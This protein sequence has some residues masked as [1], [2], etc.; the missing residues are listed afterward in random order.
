M[1]RVIGLEREA[2]ERHP[3]HVGL[4]QAGARQREVNGLGE[5]RER[6]PPRFLGNGGLPV[7]RDHDALVVLAHRSIIFSAMTAALR[8]LPLEEQT[9]PR[10]LERQAAA[11]GGKTL[12]RWGTVERSFEAMRDTAA[13]M[14]GALAAGGIEPG[15]RVVVLSENRI[16]MLDLWLGCAWRGAA[17]VPVNPAL[18]GEQLEHAFAA[19]QPKL[20]VSEPAF[21]VPAAAIAPHPA[22]PGDTAAVLYTSGSTGPAKGV[23]CPHA[24][25]YWWGILTGE[26]L[27]LGEDDVLYTS[28]PLF[29]T[30][31]LNAFCQALLAGATY[32][33]GPRFSAS[34]FWQR[35]RDA[36]AT[37]TYLLGAM[38]GILARGD[39]DRRHRV[40]VALAPATLPELVDPFRERFGVRLVNAWGSTETNLVITPPP[41]EERP[42]ALG[43]VLPEFEA[44]LDEGELVVR[45]RVPF[46]F[47]TGYLG[48]ADGAWQNGWFY[49]GDR[50]RRDD[51]DWFWFVDRTKDVIRRRGE[52]IS[53]W[54]VEQALAAH[55]SVEAAAVVPVPS[56][57]GEEEVLA[58][59]VPRGELDP[60]E[61]VRFCEDRLAHFA[62]PRYIELVA[63][64]PLT[65][66][67]K[68]A[69][70]ALRERGLTSAAWDREAAELN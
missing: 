54:E 40:R 28:L 65:A 37:V 45:S 29:H 63:D 36:D 53:S 52:N 26:L 24:Q 7:A 13:G 6:L 10:L 25:W 18:R 47:S 43:R 68:V 2:A 35:L 70:A 22:G 69:K 5:E 33:L 41:G 23:M 62:I 8:G 3:V 12:V 46:A 67:G 31:A 42:G 1:D 16:E 15:D 44:R 56:E 21:P 58:L 57:L 55:P 14:A 59:V 51:D 20:I 60:A 34:R 27:E 38:V 48:G 19:S 17:L 9:L 39:D 32:V 66:N 61:L 11:Y 49:T 50:V 4:L 64:L 30:N